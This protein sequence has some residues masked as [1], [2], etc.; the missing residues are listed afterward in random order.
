MKNII[1]LDRDP[2]SQ[3]TRFTYV[4]WAPVPRGFESI[5][6]GQ[7]SEYSDADRTEQDALAAGQVAQEVLRFQ[8]EPGMKQPDIDRA[9][10]AAYTEFETKVQNYNPKEK[11]GEYWEKGAGW[12]RGGVTRT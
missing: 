2:K 5:W 10:E 1:I 12:T 11:Y 9:L 7:V 4:L 3:R 8:G 6:A